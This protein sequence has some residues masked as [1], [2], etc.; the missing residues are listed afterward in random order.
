MR[1]GWQ[2]RCRGVIHRARA[3]RERRNR[4]LFR[5]LMGAGEINFAPTSIAHTFEDEAFEGGWR[6]EF[7]PYY[8]GASS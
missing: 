2:Q 7:R 1:M 4:Q 8:V 5:R 3:A 6:N